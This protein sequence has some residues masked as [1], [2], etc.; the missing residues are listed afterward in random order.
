VRDLDV[1]LAKEK[2]EGNL[3]WEQIALQYFGSTG[4]AAVSKARRAHAR[5]E[6]NHP[7]TSKGIKISQAQ[8]KAEEII[9]ALQRL[10]LRATAKKVFGTTDQWAVSRVRRVKEKIGGAL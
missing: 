5:V 1:W 10:S 7:G 3:T 4:S 2:E 9:E 8:A 6:R